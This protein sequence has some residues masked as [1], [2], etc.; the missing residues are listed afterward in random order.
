METKTIIKNV[1]QDDLV[2]FLSTAT[3]GSSWLGIARIKF[4]DGEKVKN[5]GDCI[6]DIWAKILLGGK[7]LYFD[8]YNAEDE[9][10]FFGELPH[11]YDN[12]HCCMSYEVK[13]ND[14]IKGMQRAIDGNFKCCCNEYSWAGRVMS[15]IIND[16]DYDLTDAELIAQIIMFGEVVY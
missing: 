6:E 14:V 9:E 1:S 3:Y 2:N 13:L 5:D 7:S 16:G 4:E 15:N 10:D 8:D 11:H 12:A